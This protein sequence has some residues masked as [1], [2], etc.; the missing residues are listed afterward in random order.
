MSAIWYSG[1]LARADNSVRAGESRGTRVPEGVG[2]VA[3][4]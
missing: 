2:F 4:L 1:D 3:L